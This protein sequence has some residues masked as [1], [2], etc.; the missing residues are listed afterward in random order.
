MLYKPTEIRNRKSEIRNFER[1]SG[2]RLQVRVFGAKRRRKFW[3]LASGF[4]LLSACMASR[5]GSGAFRRPA[6]GDPRGLL[7]VSEARML[8]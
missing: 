5:R 4:W 1:P 2:A 3:L 7:E 8:T 6:K